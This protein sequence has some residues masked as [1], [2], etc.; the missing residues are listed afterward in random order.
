MSAEQLQ[1]EP[2]GLTSNAKMDQ[3][4]NKHRFLSIVQALD[5][6]WVIKQSLPK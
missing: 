4:I 3:I 1:Q 2:I 6:D 5:L